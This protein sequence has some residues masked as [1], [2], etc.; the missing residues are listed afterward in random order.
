MDTTDPEITFDENGICSHCRRY[1]YRARTEL[2]YDKAGEAQFKKI[3]ENIKRDGEGKK[4][5]C[6]IGVS[7]G[8]DS[9]YVAYCAK[10]LGLRPLAIHFDNG[11]DSELAVSNIE[12][13]IRKLDIPLKTYVV[14]WEEFKDVQLSFLKASVPNCEIPTDHAITASVYDLAIKEGVKYILGG[15]NITTEAIMPESWGYNARDLR[16]LKAIHNKFGSQK[17]KTFPKLG[18]IKWFYGTFVRGIKVIPVLNYIHYD[19]KEAKEI[20]QRELNWRDYGGKH[21]ESIYTRFFQGYILPK[22]FGFDKRRA[23]FSTLINSGQMT[24]EEAISEMKKGAYPS[25]EAV[26]ADKIYVAK[27]LGLETG[28]FEK[29]MS[30][31]VKSHLDYKNN[32]WFFGG[33]SWLFMIIKKIVTH[34]YVAFKKAGV[35]MLNKDDITVGLHGDMELCFVAS[36][37]DTHSRKWIKY[38]ADKGYKIHWITLPEKKPGQISE[39]NKYG[40]I[41]FHVLGNFRSKG[42][43]V[44]LNIIRTWWLVKKIRPDVLHCHY[45]GVNGIIS[46]FTG[47]HPFILTAYGSDILIAP[48]SKLVRPFIKRVLRK[49]DYITCDADH[50]VRVME[51]LG[52]DKNRMEVIYFGVDTKK[53]SPGVKDE[54]L[55]NDLNFSGSPIVIS[56]RALKPIYNIETFIKAMPIILNEVPEAKFIIGGSGSE[57]EM[58]INLS[59]SLDIYDKIFFS[60]WISADTL[61]KYLRISDVYV[62][63]SLSD[64]GIASSTAEAMSCGLPSVVTDFGNNGDWVI[65]NKTGF[66]FEMKNEKELAKHVIRLLKNEAER[67]RFGSEARKLIEEKNNYYKEMEKVN[68][69]YKK[70][71]EEN[72]KKN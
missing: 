18:I 31:P 19:K 11:W 52:G 67:K 2:H 72:I 63:T 46:S 37:W 35:E 47:F 7:G 10:K 53:F 34:N 13:K 61:P 24:R 43:N 71:H 14:N 48:K 60:G 1:E 42:L 6:I 25:E 65:N 21:H 8:V 3:I 28:E 30:E 70:L 17:L 36:V 22:K 5:D 12:N 57:E 56:L 69:K 38:F 23:H 15:G 33:D 49:A 41:K 64:A 40:N 44:F 55:V 29:I 66:L 16:H 32:D 68:E 51:K 26:N 54:N 27:K 4:Y 58:L 39:F 45:A 59:K 9:T 20:I 50:M 62:S